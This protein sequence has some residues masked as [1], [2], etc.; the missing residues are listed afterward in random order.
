MDL[1][2]KYGVNKNLYKEV[3]CPVCGQ[4]T[5]DSF[6]I[7]ENCFW[8]CDDPSIPENEESPPN[9]CSVLQYKARAGR[10][11]AFLLRHSTDPQFINLDGGWANVE[12]ITKKMFI[13][14]N[15][16]EQI[17]GN[18]KK[19]RF[20]FDETKTKIRANQGHSIKGVIIEPIKATPPDILYHGTATR[21]LERIMQEGLKPMGRN[22][23]HLSS[24]I[25]TAKKVGSRHGKPVVLIVDAKQ[26][27]EDTNKLF[28]SQNGIW[29]AEFIE[30]KYIS[31]KDFNE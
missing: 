14:K 7:C 11:L 10:K 22:F 4:L 26:F 13:G 31:R 30:S 1:R 3:I 9:H 6:W 17:V 15:F 12:D 25:E 24:D 8:E 18:D 20:A 5:L 28:L 16:L 21:F 29:Q 19:Q 2:D 27:Y 23:V